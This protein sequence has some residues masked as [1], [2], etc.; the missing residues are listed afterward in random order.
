MII[1]WVILTP[2]YIAVLLAFAVPSYLMIRDLI[3]DVRDKKPL[4][5]VIILAP[6]CCGITWLWAWL[7]IIA[8]A[9]LFGH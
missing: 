8:L 3:S 6:I 4:G 1:G 7:G 2:P 9:T 5:A